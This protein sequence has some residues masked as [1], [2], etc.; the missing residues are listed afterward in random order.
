MRVTIRKIA[1]LAGVS[2]GT[3]DRVLNNR[4]GVKPEVKDKILQISSELNYVPHMAA[5]TLA[6]SKKPLTFG[7]VMPPKEIDFFGEIRDGFQ[8]AAEELKDF[9]IK[10]EY[11]YVSNREPHEAV[12]A[13]EELTR[14]G[15]SGLMFSGMDDPGVRETINR[16]S[17]YGIPVVTF[18]SD[19]FDCKRLC[20]VGQNLYKSGRIAAGLMARVTGRDAGIVIVTGN[21]KFQAHKARVEGFTDRIHEYGKALQITD[22]LECYDNYAVTY[23]K[24]LASLNKKRGIRGIYMATGHTG[25]CIDVV[26]N[27]MPSR[28][29]HIICNDLL[30]DV[31][32]GLKEGSIDFTIVQNP[33][34]QGYKPVKLLFEYFFYRRKPETEHIYTENS[35][36]LPENLGV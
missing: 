16:A 32:Q 15:I 33:F 13:I 23:D 22:I 10:L 25:A 1:E 27:H 35:I 24:L 6:Y 18:N 11:R 17:D 36:V 14:S 3:V 2:R 26:K 4:P 20:F 9:G 12:T 7:I 29:I 34:M 5:K 21:M 30:P 28:E 19:V 31:I 8:A